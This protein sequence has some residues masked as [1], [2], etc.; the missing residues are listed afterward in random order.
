[1]PIILIVWAQSYIEKGV[2]KILPDMIKGVFSPVLVLMITGVVGALLIGPVGTVAGNGLGGIIT[3]LNQFAGWLVSAILGGF[4]MFII[5]AGGHYALIPIATQN[6]ASLGYENLMMTGL[7]PGNMAMAGAAL[8]IALKTRSDSYKQYSVSASVTALL[9]V[10]QPALYGVAIP[11]KKAM[12]AVIVGGFIGGLYAGLVGLEGYALSDPG[13]AA[14]PAYISPD[15]TW[16]NFINAVITILISFGI[17]FAIAYVGK[18]NELSDN[19]INS[20]TATK[21]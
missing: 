3:W 18:F 2:N 9:G 16:G 12:T 1:M 6:L 20:I 7:L 17:S 19:E 10:S 14:L 15:G 13:L 8:A 5:M 4:G 11:I 21:K